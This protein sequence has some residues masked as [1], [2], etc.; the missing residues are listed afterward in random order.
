[1][2]SRGVRRKERARRERRGAVKLHNQDVLHALPI[3]RPPTPDLY[4]NL[5][6]CVADLTAAKQ[7]VRIEAEIDP[8]LEAAEIHRRVYRAGAYGLYFKRMDCPCFPQDSFLLRAL[9][10]MD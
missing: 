9:D 6:E 10:R 4:R 5:R 8:C 2:I 1:M 3:L 7:L